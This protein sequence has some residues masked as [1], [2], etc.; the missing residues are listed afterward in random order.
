MNYTFEKIISVFEPHCKKNGITLVKIEDLYVSILYDPVSKDFN[1][2]P[3]PLKTPQEM[4]A[5]LIRDY[6][7]CF[8]TSH[9]TEIDELPDE[10]E[11]QLENEL[12]LL[13]KKIE[14]Q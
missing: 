4:L 3:A 13:I 2:R 14:L 1:C 11:A 12:S 5:Y 7:I 10:L 8:A 6:S 9:H